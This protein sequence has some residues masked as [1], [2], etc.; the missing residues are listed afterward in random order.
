M[1]R[2]F[3]AKSRAV[4]CAMSYGQLTV[5]G[6]VIKPHD[7]RRWTADQLAGRT[8]SLVGRTGTLP[9]SRRDHG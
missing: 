1:E 9:G 3:G 4:F 8:V 6:Y 2:I 7:E 5:D